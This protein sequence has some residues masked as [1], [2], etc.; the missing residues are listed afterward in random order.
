MSGLKGNDGPATTSILA[1]FI[2]T[3]SGGAVL[4]V[5]FMVG[6]GEDYTPIAV[7]LAFIGIVIVLLLWAFIEDGRRRRAMNGA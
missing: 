1:P 3:V 5:I 6:A 7:C 4:F 2:I